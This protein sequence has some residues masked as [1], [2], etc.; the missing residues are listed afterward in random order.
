MRNSAQSDLGFS[1]GAID[2]NSSMRFE[3]FRAEN[4]HCSVFCIEM[5]RITDISEGNNELSV[6]CAMNLHLDSNELFT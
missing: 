3:I 2:C 6:H 5:Y 1:S 4:N